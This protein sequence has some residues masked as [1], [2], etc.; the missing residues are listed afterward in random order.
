[1]AAI[2]RDTFNRHRPK[3][4]L[5]LNGKQKKWGFILKKCADEFEHRR[6]CEV[7]IIFNITYVILSRYKKR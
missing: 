3:S 5:D 7:R 4:S 6:K 2:I 1:M